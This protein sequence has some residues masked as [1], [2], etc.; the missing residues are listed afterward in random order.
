MAVSSVAIL[1]TDLRGST[2]MYERGGDAPAFARVRRHFEALTEAVRDEGGAVVKT[3]GDAVMASFPKPAAGIRAAVRMQERIA[4]L[5]AEMGGEPLVVKVGL[6]CGPCIVV[7]ANDRLDYFGTT[8]N[9]AARLASQ[10]RGGDIVVSDSVAADPEASRFLRG[11]EAGREEF[12]AALKGVRSARRL[13]R[14][15]PR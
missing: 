11:L 1:F 9:V 3:L 6:H 7:G 13:V 14:I 4:L 5:N 2:E 8:A 10:C 15:V 12:T